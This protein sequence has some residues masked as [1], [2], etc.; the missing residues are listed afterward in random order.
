MEAPGTTM[1]MAEGGEVP[2]FCDGPH[3]PD[4]EYFAKG[5]IV[6]QSTSV[7]TD[8]GETLG[9]A[10]IHGGLLG[11]LQNTGHAKLAN[12]GDKHH[13]ILHEAKN[14]AA[15]PIMEDMEQSNTH[16][17]RLGRHLAEGN[18]DKAADMMHGSPLTGN[19]SKTNLRL[20]LK[21]LAA[22]MMTEEPHPEGFRSAVNYLNTSIKGQESLKQVSADVLRGR[23]TKISP[24]INTREQL[25]SHLDS[26][27]LNPEQAIDVGGHL[28]HYLPNHGTQLGALTGQALTYLE[29]IKPKDWQGGPLDGPLPINKVQE[30]AYNRQLDIAQQPLM[31]LK[32]MESGSLLPQDVTTLSAIYPSLYRKMSSTLTEG[33]INTKSEGASIPY[34]VKRSLSTFLGS[35]M[36]ATMTQGAMLA[37]I[38]A[39][40]PKVP[41]EPPGK[42]KKPS[43]PS[44]AQQEKLNGMFETETQQLQ[45][46]EK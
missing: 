32:H 37:A 3:K 20:I 33:L 24:D 14:H 17:T 41:Q 16:G 31:A 43:K 42:T 23:N 26:L 38:Q 19:A 29:S 34:A 10:S 8:P 44:L 7:D 22:G 2:Q 35:P 45:N 18:H 5:G 25:K 27:S 9:M 12:L 36:D 21:H 40:T 13:R 4:C 39:N 15:T 1:H 6:P 11:L 46:K 28:S 30:N